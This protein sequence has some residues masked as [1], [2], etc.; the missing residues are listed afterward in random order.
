MI[1]SFRHRS[2]VLALLAVAAPWGT[3]SN[4]F[5]PSTPRNLMTTTSSQAMRTFGQSYLPN[6]I[7][8]NKVP[9]RQFSALRMSADDF[10]EAKYTE[11]AWSIIASVTKVADY[12]QTQT[13][14]SPYLMDI[15]L[16]PTKHSAGDNAEAA[17][18]VVDKILSSA[19]VDV[20]QLRKELE[21][22]FSKQPKVNGDNTGQKQMGKTFGQVLETARQT[23]SVL[24]D[25]FV[26]TEGLLLSLVKEDNEF[27]R[28]ALL[29]QGIKYTDVLDAVKKSRK[30]SGPAISRSAEKMY[31]ALLKYG[32]DFTEQAEEGKLDPVI[33]RDDEIRRAIQILSRRTKNNPVLIG[34]PGVGK[35]AVAE[36]IAQRMVTGDVPD[37]LKGCRLIGLDLAA[38]VAGASLRGE[39]E[40]RLKAVLEE[41]TLSDGE[42][43]LFI[44][45][46]HTM[47]GAGVSQV[48]QRD[49]LEYC[50]AALFLTGFSFFSNKFAVCSRFN[51]CIQLVE[52]RFG[53]WQASLY[54][55]HDNQGVSHVH[56]KG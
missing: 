8:N 39:F 40:E 1:I 33:G 50:D 31:D 20:K 34:D 11:A 15:L 47:V 16:N 26:S 37:S 21:S 18:R 13:V 19:G 14:E 32:I 36:G 24:G 4:A 54:W 44:D 42:I 35:T 51:G 23:M 27:T 48:Y 53:S 10:I 2:A 25:S 12:Y 43:I 6:S 38:L 41:V 9:R 52:A 30:K 49:C 7:V 45:E 17:K 56:R 28:D 29:R 55:C 46:M 3:P 5:V 22:Y